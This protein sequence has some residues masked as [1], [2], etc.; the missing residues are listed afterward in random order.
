MP[1]HRV[2]DLTIVMAAGVAILLLGT[3]AAILAPPADPIDAG[4]STYSA[5]PRGTK[6]VYLTLRALGYDAVRSIEPM[7]AVRSDPASTTM[8]LSGD[9]APSEQDRRAVREFLEQGGTLI[10]IGANGAYALGLP[11]PARATPPPFR[12]EVGTQ[13]RLSLSAV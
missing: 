5:G 1:A 12:E 4:T 8:I 13:A 3:A 11:A 9:E 7:T 2:S 10:A 6:G